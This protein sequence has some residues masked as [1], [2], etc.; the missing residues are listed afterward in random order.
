MTFLRVTVFSVLTLLLFT[1][2]AN[3]LPQVQSDPPKQEKIDAASLDM[4]GMI[5]LGEMLFHG[6]GTC[7][8]CHNDLGRAPNMLKIDLGKDFNAHISDPKY[9]GVAKGKTGAAAV[10]AY[11]HESMVAPSAYVV[12][13]YGKKGTHDKVSPMP[14]IDA[15]PIDLKPVE[16]NAVIAF[17]QNQAGYAPT[18]P[19]PSAAQSS[20]AKAAS[21]KAAAEPAGPVTSAKAAFDKF[22]CSTCHDLN[23][24]GADVGPDLRG[25]GARLGRDKIMQSILTPN[26]VIAKGYDADIM[27]QDFAQQMT[28]SELNLIVNYLMKWK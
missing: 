12:S 2:F 11:I 4:P 16:I 13:G 27:P 21:A 28:V 15:A 8:L 18:V 7:T 5:R 1:G 17:L 24:S 3:V 10:E 14:K 6:K 22:G 9:T 19:L 26:A 25:V 23:G 20:A